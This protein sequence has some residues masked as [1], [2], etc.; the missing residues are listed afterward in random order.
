VSS[1]Q[2]SYPSRGQD[3]RTLRNLDQFCNQY[4][5]ASL[6][7]YTKERVGQEISGISP[8]NAKMTPNGDNLRVSGHTR[9]G[10]HL[11]GRNKSRLTS[12][13]NR[14][15]QTKTPLPE[16]LPSNSNANPN[17]EVRYNILVEKNVH[18]KN[19]RWTNPEP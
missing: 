1:I 5:D 14:I 15:R 10:S 3:L 9:T 16:N 19:G 13:Y 12:P 6:V 18:A 4:L 8:I 7:S 17:E 2:E 11:V